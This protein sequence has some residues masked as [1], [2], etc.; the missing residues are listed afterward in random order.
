MMSSC[1]TFTDLWLLVKRILGKEA[2]EEEF[3]TLSWL[4]KNKQK[5]RRTTQRRDRKS[6]KTALKSNSEDATYRPR[7][8]EI[9]S[10]ERLDVHHLSAS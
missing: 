8:E 10:S 1:D 5:T 9:L 2:T 3:E 4:L 6:T 7:A